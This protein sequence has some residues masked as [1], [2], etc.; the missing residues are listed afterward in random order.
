MAKLYGTTSSRTVEITVISGENLRVDRRSI[1]KNA[2]VVVRPD[3][4][5]DFRMTEIDADGGSY[6]RWDKKFVLDLPAQ[7]PAVS[8]EVYCKTAF[9][10]RVVGVARVPVSD[11]SGAYVPETYL[12]FLS[13]RLRD[14]RG[15][16]NGIINISVRS[17]VPPARAYTYSA[18]AS[19]PTP[20]SSVGVPVG[21]NNYG[22]GVV[23]GLPV[24]YAYH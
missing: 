24:L 10:N 8:V 4:G 22:G 15:E 13:Y 17:K 21:K 23:T 18:S 3:G 16:R 20:A 9:G 7:A 5:S 11:F 14:Q 6:P 2:F 19:V 12:H 1:K